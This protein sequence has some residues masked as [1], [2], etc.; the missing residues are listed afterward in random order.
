MA[1]H[2][3]AHPGFKAVEAEIAK[4][5]GVKDAGAILGAANKK[6]QE[7]A[8]RGEHVSNPRM[9]RKGGRHRG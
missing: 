9:L 1:E 7:K 5:K 6:Q 4:Q 3:K 2:S 8:A